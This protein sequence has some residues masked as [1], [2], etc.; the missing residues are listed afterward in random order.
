MGAKV[1]RIYLN[2]KLNTQILI[3]NSVTRGAKIGSVKAAKRVV[4]MT[5][6]KLKNRGIC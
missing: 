1:L 3:M 4:F 2:L 6:I 5:I